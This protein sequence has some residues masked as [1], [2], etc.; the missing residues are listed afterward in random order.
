MS[1]STTIR[2]P[3]STTTLTV[4]NT[5]SKLRGKVR[6]ARANG[7]MTPAT[8]VE[9]P[10]RIRELP[11][12]TTREQAAKLRSPVKP[13][14]ARPAMELDQHRQVPA[15]EPERRIVADRLVLRELQTVVASQAPRRW[16]V[17]VS[18]VPSVAWT[19]AAIQKRRVTVGRQVAKV[20]PPHN[21]P[22]EAVEVAEAEVAVPAVVAAAVVAVAVVEDK[23]GRI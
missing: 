23:E 7:S 10:T 19:K 8:G 4:I 22:R 14:E 9:S 16:K 12:S 13:I 11:R 17:V 6:L 15:P 2:I 21:P 20:C 3:T 1:I 5:S 18:R